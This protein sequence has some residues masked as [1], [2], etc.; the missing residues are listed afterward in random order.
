MLG[1][2]TRRLLSLNSRHEDFGRWHCFN[3]ELQASSSFFANKRRAVISY[4][5]SYKAGAMLAKCFT[6]FHEAQ[7]AGMVDINR[8]LAYQFLQC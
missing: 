6:N 1:R 4:G 3:D 5:A 7:G 2:E 8:W